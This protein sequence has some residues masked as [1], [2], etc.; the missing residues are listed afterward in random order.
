MAA[1]YDA[2]DAQY[3]AHYD[4]DQL[5]GPGTLLVLC[6]IIPLS[7][8]TC[9]APDKMVL[10]TD[11]QWRWRNSRVLTAI[12]YLNPAEATNNGHVDTDCNGV[13]T[14]SSTSLD[15]GGK[16]RL[17]DGGELRTWPHVQPAASSAA[18]GTEAKAAAAEDVLLPVGGSVV[19]FDSRRLRHAV[20]PAQRRRVALSAWFVSAATD[21][22]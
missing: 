20:C 18:A 8:M 13:Q 9:R 19:L 17:E 11:G 14:A 6:W 1:V 3:A 15:E 22:T 21:L 5:V 7:T 12:V 4:N 16:W 2:H 10:L